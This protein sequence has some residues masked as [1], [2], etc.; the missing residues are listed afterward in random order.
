MNT[1]KFGNGEWYGKKDTI[2]AYNDLNSNFK[3]LAFNFDRASSATVVNKQGLI[4][5]V[6]SGEP[7]IDYSNDAKGALLLEPS[8]S[9]SNIESENFLAA[10]YNYVGRVTRTSNILTSPNGLQTSDLITETTDS[11]THLVG[12]SSWNQSIADTSVSV[13]AKTNGRRYIVLGN[14]NMSPSMNTWFDLEN[15][16][17]GTQSPNLIDARIESYGN[18]WYRCSISYLPNKG[19][20]YPTIYLSNSN[21]GIS[22]QGDGVSGVYLWGYQIEVNSSYATSYIPTSGSVVTRVADACSNGANEQV[23]NSTEGVLY[24]EISALADDGTNRY[25]SLKNNTTV[26][27]IRIGYITSSNRIVIENYKS[28]ALFN[29]FNYEVQDVKTNSK[30]AFKWKDNDF[31]LYINGLNVLSNTSVTAWGSDV[32]Q[33]LQ[34]D[35]HNGGNDFYGNVKDVRVYNTALT[36]SELINLTTI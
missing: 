3:P 25:I 21:G 2:L 35:Q 17:V 7:R 11:G 14:A 23:I 8:R 32:F 10:N 18:G 9:N 29:L 20:T 19:N 24:A 36:D 4:E 12:Q 30:I 16:V 27:I 26:D 13:F 5:T 28:G 6:G 1:L 31:Q 34:F 33:S 22:Y 15:G